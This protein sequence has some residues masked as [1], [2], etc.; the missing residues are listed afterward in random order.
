MITLE[1]PT[2]AT[3]AASS[4]HNVKIIATPS[5]FIEL[6]KKYNIEYHEDNS[7]TDK[8]NFDFEFYVP[9]KGLYFTVYDWKHYEPLDINYF[10]SFNIG[11]KDRMASLEA[12]EILN[13]YLNKLD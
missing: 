3:T 6:C 1:Q 11:A 2:K 8:V 9:E 12:K 10:Y 7:G 13:E 5:N 4:H